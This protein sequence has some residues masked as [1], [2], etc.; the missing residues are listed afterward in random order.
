MSRRTSDSNKAIRL[1]WEI[2]QK[3]VQEGKGTR[4]WT[5]DQQRDI[6]DPSKGKAYDDEG[7]AFQGQHMKSVEAYPEYQGDPDNIQFLTR[8]EHLEA[9]D[10][11]W[12]NSTNW[13]YD[14]ITK[15]K[16]IMGDTL[17]PCRILTLS[18]P[19]AL[20][21]V[22]EADDYI[23]QLDQKQMNTNDNRGSENNVNPEQISSISSKDKESKQSINAE[24]SGIDEK[25][26]HKAT[27]VVTNAVQKQPQGFISRVVKK[28]QYVFSPVVNYA[29]EHPME[30]VLLV[31]TAAAKLYDL[32]RGGD[33]VISIGSSQNNDLTSNST[34]PDIENDACEENEEITADSNHSSK[35]PHERKGYEGYRWKGKKGNQWRE[36]V[37]IKP[38]RIHPE[39]FQ[40]DSDK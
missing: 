36:K 39:A 14:P 3:L 26:Y 32:A 9:H 18:E 22:K 15:Q 21:V 17:V 2:E 25:E 28:I 24:K 40:D 27:T 4:D 38:T 20:P 13:Y 7:F 37:P 8:I 31:F 35:R 16:T 1:K 19:V 11:S 23:K 6:L 10:G 29:K 12:K 30:T 5:P 34:E 33:D